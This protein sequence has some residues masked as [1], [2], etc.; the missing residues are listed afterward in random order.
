MDIDVGTRTLLKLALLPPGI[1]LLLLLIGWLFARRFFG[2]VLILL[3]IAAL[4]ALYT[5]V[6]LNYLATQLETVPALTPAQLENTRA[7]A[8]LVFLAGVRRHNPEL[9]GADALGRMSL[10]RI[11]YGLTLHRITDLPIILSGGSVRGDTTPPAQLGSEWL[12][13]QVGITPLAVD[14]RSRDTRENTLNSAELLQ[15]LGIGRVLLVTHAYHMPRALLS[16]RTA[17]IDAIPA[18]FAFEGVPP[19]L[20]GPSDP[21]DWLPHPGYLGRSYLVLHEMV[22]LIWYGLNQHR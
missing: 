5:P 1:L 11:D 6:G 14:H 22:G 8:I 2:R 16:A 20:Q 3:G 15:S 18:P 10:Q 9:G 17:G 13:Q 21:K 12:R 7:D 19:D 4:Y